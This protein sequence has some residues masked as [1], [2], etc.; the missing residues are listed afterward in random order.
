MAG[1]PLQSA[2]AILILGSGYDN[3]PGWR[4]G[5]RGIPQAPGFLPCSQGR[6]RAGHGASG[7]AL[8]RALAAAIA[9]AH[10]QFLARQAA[11]ADGQF[12]ALEVSLH[13]SSRPT[14]AGPAAGVA[15]MAG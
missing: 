12:A 7:R 1:A 15:R 13:L 5:G 4:A 14:V 2:L 10:G 9:S 8:I 3:N 6:L 11:V